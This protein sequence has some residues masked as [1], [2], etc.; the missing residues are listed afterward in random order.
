MTA[1]PAGGSASPG[2]V[3]RLD[4]ELAWAE[5]RIW[6][7]LEVPGSASLDLLH[8]V[9]Q[10]AF[11]WQDCHLHA[12]ST[13]VGDFGRPDWGQFDVAD[14]TL[15]RLDEAARLGGLFRY[16]YDFNA[17][18]VHVLRVTDVISPSP[19]VRY[20]RCVGGE[21]AGPIEDV[22][23]LVAYERLIAALGDKEHPEHETY[24]AALGDG[25]RFDPERFRVDDLNRRLA[26]LTS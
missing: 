19:H 21:R 4:V 24:L 6:R 18:W 17:D 1:T 13:D 26:L 7:L 3:Y 14:S 25:E 9:L 2:A 16:L 12:F 20:P 8:R 11:G 5:P 15:V 22:G 23:S 10:A